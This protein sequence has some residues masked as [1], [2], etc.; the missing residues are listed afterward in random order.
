MRSMRCASTT[1]RRSATAPSEAKWQARARVVSAAEP[2]R[3]IDSD[4]WVTDARDA[5]EHLLTAA[6]YGVPELDYVTSWAN[7]PLRSGEARLI[8]QVQALATTR[9]AGSPLYASPGHWL[10]L[11]AGRVVAETLRSARGGSRLV[12]LDVWTGDRIHVLAT[13]RTR[14]AVPL[15]SAGVRSVS[16]H[17]RRVRWHV[18]GSRLVLRLQPGERATVALTRKSRACRTAARCARGW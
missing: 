12:G 4:G 13:A 8:G 2:G 17:G 7:G 10:S 6:V 9:P 5:L 11:H 1:R 15:H 3:L 16:A 18:S 14:V